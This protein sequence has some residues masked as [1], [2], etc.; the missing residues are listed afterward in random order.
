MRRM[1]AEPLIGPL[2]EHR[3]RSLT[4]LEPPLDA[5]RGTARS[6]GPLVTPVMPRV[7]GLGHS[8]VFMNTPIADIIAAHKSKLD[9][10]T[11]GLTN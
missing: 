9:L 2:S 6:R 5:V 11:L 8:E 4:V 10:K 3:E 7:K 1:F